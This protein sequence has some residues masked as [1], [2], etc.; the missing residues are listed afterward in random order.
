MKPPQTERSLEEIARL[1][2]RADW[3]RDLPVEQLPKIE[4]T[5]IEA[6]AITSDVSK[7]D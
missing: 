6:N 1:K 4:A 3:L 5:P 2:S 7:K